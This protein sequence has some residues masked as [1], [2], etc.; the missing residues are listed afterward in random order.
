M[1]FLE[2]CVGIRELL[3]GSN[4]RYTSA[5]TFMFTDRSD[6][7]LSSLTRKEVLRWMKCVRGCGIPILVSIAGADTLT[8]SI[9]E[10]NLQGK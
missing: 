7:I 2:T 9:S 10:S 5:F 1:V 3:G 6:L 4:T 8:R